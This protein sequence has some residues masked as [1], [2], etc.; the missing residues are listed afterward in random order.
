ML[1]S[2]FK[3]PLLCIVVW[4]ALSAYCAQSLPAGIYNQPFPLWPT[5][6]IWLM[7]HTGPLLFSWMYYGNGWYHFP[8]AT[9]VCLG[10]AVVFLSPIALHL[11]RPGR[12]P[13]FGVIFG[14]TLWFLAGW[15]L[16]S[17]AAD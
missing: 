15:L 7:A 13:H 11:Y 3:F 14:V 1:G 8:I 10:L 9:A 17:I 2:R 6:M 16:I 4:S 12:W 5:F